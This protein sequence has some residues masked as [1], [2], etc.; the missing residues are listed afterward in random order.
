MTLDLLLTQLK[1]FASTTNMNGTKKEKVDT[2]YLLTNNQSKSIKQNLQEGDFG[3]W[4]TPVYW[5]VF[6]MVIV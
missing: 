5:C 3:V 6:R 4:S 1:F 2:Y